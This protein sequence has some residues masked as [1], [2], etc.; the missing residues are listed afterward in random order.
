MQSFDLILLVHLLLWEVCEEEVCWGKHEEER[1]LLV[2]YTFWKI[3]ELSLLVD[4]G[5]NVARGAELMEDMMTSQHGGCAWELQLSQLL[6]F[7][8]ILKKI[9]YF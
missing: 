2:Q 6:F 9:L 7:F 1:I 8:L 3:L 5:Q 4:P